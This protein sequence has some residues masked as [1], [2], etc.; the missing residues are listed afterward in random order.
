LNFLYNIFSGIASLVVLPVV[1]LK[2]LIDDRAYLGFLGIY[3]QVPKCES[4]KTRIWIHASSVGE[5]K[6]ALLTIER[7]RNSANDIE[8]IL[9]VFTPRGMKVARE[10]AG[11]DVTLNYPPL[12]LPVFVRRA[13]SKFK[14]SVVVLTETELWPGLMRGAYSRGIPVAIINGRLTDK[15]LVHYIALKSV[16]RPLVENLSMIH[17]QS[18]LD[19]DRYR[20]LG[21]KD[22]VIF[23]EDNL[24]TAALVKAGEKFDRESVEQDFGLSNRDRVFVAGSTREGEDEIILKAYVKARQS[25]GDLKI[26][27]APR[28]TTRIPTIEK[29]ITDMGHSYTLRS[30]IQSNPEDIII[31]DTMGELWRV[32]GIGTAAF[33][34]GSLVPIGGHNPLEPL[35]LGV[36]TCFGPSM[37][38]SAE[39]TAHLLENKFA[40]TVHSADDIA[41]FVIRSAGG[42][43]PR[44]D[45][46]RLASLFASEIDEVAERILKL[47]GD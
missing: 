35:S 14:P 33:V 30:Q 3:K 31:L 15:T 11:S 8:F 39:L 5:V 23:G 7:L 45:T 27:I 29:L 26:I 10:E 34:G 1:L 32:Y 38:N 9:T 22:S 37:E 4:G 25:I 19:Y 41:D 36:P 6:A 18:H 12:D 2:A 47:A 43:I 16:F 46:K 40:E 42:D 17:T 28:H 20:R 24:K 21:A 13:Y 44:S